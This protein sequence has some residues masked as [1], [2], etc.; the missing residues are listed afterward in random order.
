MNDACA[1]EFGV[2]YFE[3]IPVQH[4]EVCELPGLRALPFWPSS[5]A[6]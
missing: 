1:G 2:G 4:D 3:D 5:K 6:A